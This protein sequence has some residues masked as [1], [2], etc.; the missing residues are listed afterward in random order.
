MVAPLTSRERFTL[1][2][3]H[4]EPDRVPID[5]GSLT[6]TIRTVDAYNRLKNH[7]RL[8]LNKKI[9]HF[10]DEHVIPDEEILRALHVDTV[11]L[12]MNVPKT[13]QR[14]RLDPHTIV[15]E[16]QVPWYKAPGS[17]YTFPSAHPMKTAAMEEIEKVP[18][19]D[20]HEPSRFEGLPAKAEQLFKETDYAL[21]ADGIT[22][23]GVFDMSWHL[24]GM[25]N[26]F[27]DMLIHP[28]FTASLF[29]R[30]TDYYVAVYRNY[31]QAVGKFIQMVI[32]YD[33]LSGQDG[34]LISPQLYRRFVKPCHRRIF[35]VIKDNTP[36]KICVHTCGSVYALLDDYVE[37]GVDVLN[38][39]QISAQ[40]MDPVR[41]KQKYGASLSFHG[42]IDTQRFL[43]RATPDQVREEA[44]RMI[45]ILGPGG[46]YLFT[47][48]H[49][50]QP[51]VSPENIV[52]LF[53]AAA[54]YGKYPLSERIRT[55]G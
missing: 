48:C 29:K 19:P 55:H 9:R 1:A 27:L 8:A 4:K 10:A 37:L 21:V 16:W 5:L 45:G 42:G 41:L 32:Y 13:W 49:S 15:D 30:L 43:P 47:S 11:Y 31:M 26:I 50:I 54:E 22:G 28:D 23:V 12:R 34:P 20:P 46:G 24:R 52:V 6:S 40:D 36:A 39:V 44:R 3:N 25:E 18:W 38:P 7:M 35:Q 33:D 53:S 14:V 51:D 17:L 2:L